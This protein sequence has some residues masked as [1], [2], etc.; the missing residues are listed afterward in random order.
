MPLTLV[1]VLLVI[2]LVL[3]LVIV[4]RR[5]LLTRDL[6][7]FDCSLR[8]ERGG[9]SNGRW[10]LG[11]ARYGTDRLDWYRLFSMSPRPWRSFTRA[12]LMILEQRRAQSGE[13]YS[14][15]PGA[16]IV[17][18][19]YGTLVLELAMTESAY[20]GLSTWLESAPPGPRTLLS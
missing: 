1:A 14:V 12:R 5:Y 7:S 17:R 8:R 9:H 18:C 3:L 2:V 20:T 13:G 19:A 6:G 11:V 4:L 10:M 15:M 16:V